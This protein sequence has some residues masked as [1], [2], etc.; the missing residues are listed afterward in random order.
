MSDSP[1]A[2]APA[3]SD[4]FDFDA[5][6]A[7]S[8]SPPSASAP[9]SAN[10]AISGESPVISS[11]KAAELAHAQSHAHEEQ[12]TFHDFV[13]SWALY[14]DPV[15][16][17]VVAGAVLG[18]LGVFVVL[19]RAV[20]VTAAVSQ[21]AALGVALAFWLGIYLGV[22]PPPVLCALLLALLATAALAF[23]TCRSTHRR[24]ALAS[25]PCPVPRRR[26]TAATVAM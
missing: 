17:G 3:A 7:P 26:E 14:R 19:R 25:S 24:W 13:S 16:C 22:T 1:A 12:P 5:L 6:L 9:A 2:P 18:V 15:I 20:F 11:T 23:R 8:A 10:P 21:S 4:D